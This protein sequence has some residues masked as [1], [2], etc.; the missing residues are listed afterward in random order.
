MKCWQWTAKPCV[1]LLLR[2]RLRERNCYQS[3]IVD[4][5]TSNQ[6]RAIDVASAS[7]P[8]ELQGMIEGGEN[9]VYS[10]SI[11]GAKKTQS[12]GIR[13]GSDDAPAVDHCQSTVDA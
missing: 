8:V 11:A 12:A 9:G 7:Q 1:G 2:E 6:I 4:G 10:V 3:I 5:F 13:H